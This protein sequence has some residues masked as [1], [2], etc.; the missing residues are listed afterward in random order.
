MTSLHER[1]TFPASALFIDIN[2]L[3]L[4]VGYVTAMPTEMWTVCG[5]TNCS[6]FVFASRKIY[7]TRAVMAQVNRLT[8]NIPDQHV[9]VDQTLFTGRP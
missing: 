3:W 5:I 4:R 1:S 2:R 6:V 9:H 7:L 8:G